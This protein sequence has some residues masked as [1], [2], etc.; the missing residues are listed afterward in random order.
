MFTPN[1]INT[2]AADTSLAAKLEAI[3]EDYR[4]GRVEFSYDLFAKLV[5]DYPQK[6]NALQSPLPDAIPAKYLPRD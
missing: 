3:L 2:S 4:E 6:G 5:Y 1:N